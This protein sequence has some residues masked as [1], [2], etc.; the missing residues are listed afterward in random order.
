MLV[1]L[2]TRKKV[3]SAAVW[4]SVK[5]EP[6]V[7]LKFVEPAKFILTRAVGLKDLRTSGTILA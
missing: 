6:V 4:G 3:G 7:T 5:R 1:L 2:V